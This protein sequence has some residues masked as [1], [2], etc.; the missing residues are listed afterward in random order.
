MKTRHY[1]GFVFVMSLAAGLLCILRIQPDMLIDEQN[2]IKPIIQHMK[3]GLYS[4]RY[5]DFPFLFYEFIFRIYTFISDSY[6]YLKVG[7]SVNILLFIF[8]INLFSRTLGSKLKLGWSIVAVFLFSFSPA[9]FYSGVILKTE[10]LHIIE[11]LFV[12]YFAQKIIQNGP[13]RLKVLFIAVFAALAMSTK[14]NFLM[15][16]L[17]YI[18]LFLYLRKQHA[19]ESIK[20][21]WQLMFRRPEFYF[22]HFFYVLVILATWHSIW[23]LPGIIEFM[24]N[25]AYFLDKPAVLRAVDELWSFPYG[26]YSYTFYVTLPLAAGLAVFIL[27]LTGLILSRIPNEVLALWGSFT[28]V[29]LL[30]LTHAT[31]LRTPHTFTLAVPF[32]ILAAAYLLQSVASKITQYVLVVLVVGHTI[33]N[34]H[35]IVE[36]YYQTFRAAISVKNSDAMTL[37]TRD[38]DSTVKLNVETFEQ[39]VLK[40]KPDRIFLLDS[41]FHNF[42]KY[43]TSDIFRKNCKFYKKLLE[44]QWPYKL[45]HRKQLDLP[46]RWLIYTDEL[47]FIF[48]DFKKKQP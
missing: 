46:L 45:E 2:I 28:V 39:A 27:G 37:I 9:I 32:F 47:S 10:T 5:P 3:G 29:L 42:C 12:I 35:S 36:L 17:F 48:Y 41:Y 22:F 6:D 30:F 34:H 15:P 4:Y 26:R 1:K 24:Q 33:F 40:Q 8:S 19:S 31:M 13:G 7:R 25:D 23:N 38:L 18:S 11:L 21:L 16:L 43:K 44:E 14:Y 20:S